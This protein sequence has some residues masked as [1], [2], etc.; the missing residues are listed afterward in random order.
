M[1][2]NLKYNLKDELLAADER[3]KGSLS[4]LGMTMLSSPTYNNSMRSVMF[5]SH[6]K[7]LCNLIKPDFPGFFTN[8]ENTVGAHNSAYKKTKHDMTVFRKIAKYGDLVENPFVYILFV[9]DEKTRTYDVWE[10][11]DAENLTEVFGYEYNNEIIDELSEGD[12]IPENTVVYK[13]R[14]YD[15]YMNYGY[16]KNVKL[17]YSLDPYTSEDACVCSESL[18]KNM[19]SIEINKVPIGVNQNDILLNIYGTEDH[20]KPFPDLGEYSNGDVAIKRTIITTQ[21]L[22]DFK[23]NALQ[24][25]QDS[26]VNYYKYGRVV[27]IDIY[28]NNPDLV[29]DPF[30]EQIFKYLRSQTEYYTEIKETCEEIFAMGAKYTHNLDYLYKRACEHLDTK[31]AWKDDTVFGNLSIEITLKSQIGL[32]IGQKLTGRYGNKS[33]ISQIRPDDEMPYYYDENGNKHSVDLIFNVLAIINRTTAFPIYELSMN[34]ICNNVSA[35]NS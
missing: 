26:D 34:F 16:G 3:L 35:K 28:C 33:V 21:M 23:D 14:S 2:E 5:T 9:F 29:E 15:E 13:S 25:D 30:T 4:L 12:L 31:K 8:G 17:M 10:R 20:Y 19:T 22:N 7:Q 24:K 1:A 32:Q 11:K 27:D 18:A 6:L